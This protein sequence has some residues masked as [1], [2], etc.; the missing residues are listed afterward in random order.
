[1]PDP[2]G[3]S[4]LLAFQFSYVRTNRKKKSPIAR[5]KK[6]YPTSRVKNKSPNLLDKKISPNL[7]GQ[8]KIT[9]PLG[10]KK[11]IQPLGTKKS[12]NLLG[13]KKITRS[14]GTTK[15]HANSWDKKNTHMAPNY[16]KWFQ[17]TMA[18]AN[19]YGNGPTLSQMV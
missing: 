9:Q 13:Q 1:M 4:L 7:L 10:T 3:A 15:N 19:D 12:P 5:D 8:Q 18:K 2:R 14:F 6:N 17:M 16:S 11:I